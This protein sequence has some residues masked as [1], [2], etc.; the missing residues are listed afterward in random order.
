MMILSAWRASKGLSLDE[1]CGLLGFGSKGY[2]SDVENGVVTLPFRRALQV[3]AK[4]GGAVDLASLLS[5]E[6]GRLL[7]A[8]SA[9]ATQPST[10][11]EPCTVTP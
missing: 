2:L 5:E 3:V 6:D 11:P 9:F 4:T 1:C 10:T 7:A 8:H